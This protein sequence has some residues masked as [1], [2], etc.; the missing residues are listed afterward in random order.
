MARKKKSERAVSTDKLPEHEKTTEDQFR[1]ETEYDRQYDLPTWEES[2]NVPRDLMIY[3][4]QVDK[5]V[6]ALDTRVSNN[7]KLTNQNWSNLKLHTDIGDSD[8]ERAKHPHNHDEAYSGVGHKHDDLYSGVGHGH[9][10]LSPTTHTHGQYIDTGP[11]HQTK[12]GPLTA[13]RL[14][15][16]AGGLQGSIEANSGDGNPPGIY[17]KVHGT[18]KV[19]YNAANSSTE[20]ASRGPAAVLVPHRAKKHTRGISLS[21]LEAERKAPKSFDLAEIDLHKIKTI[22]NDL[23]PESL[24]EAG[25]DVNVSAIP[26]YPDE[27]GVAGES[28]GDEIAF[29]LEDVITFL[30]HKVQ[31]QDKEIQQLRS[32]VK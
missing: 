9:S 13:M 26:P 28:P 1:T 2:P 20:T 11:V 8:A 25:F 32:K 5:D 27:D 12:S 29:A 23:D 21:E 22:N 17:L 18:M 10:D 6:S 24:R 31:E 16:E 7:S 15:T 3:G 30:V 14:Y 4:N 19:Y